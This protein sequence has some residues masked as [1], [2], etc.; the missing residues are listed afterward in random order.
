MI[1]RNNI[2]HYN[3]VYL[4]ALVGL[5]FG[6]FILHPISMALQWIEMDP[7]TFNF[8]S[9][10]TY[11]AESFVHSFKLHMV[12]MS[13]AFGIL[14]LLC[15]IGSGF[16]YR[17]IKVKNK[18]INAKRLLLNKSIPS[19]IKSGENEFVE[20]KS[21]LRY[22]YRQIKTNKNLEE[23]ILK[24]IV[25]FFNAKGGILIIGVDDNGGIL[26]LANDYIT[27]KHKNKDG[28]QQK[29]IQLVSNAFGKSMCSFIHTSFH[30]IDN[31]EI[32]MVLIEP[33][34]QPTYLR[35]ED[36]TLFYLRT[37]NVTNVLTTQE[38]VKYL[39]NRKL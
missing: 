24:S 31:K 26:G 9:L 11:I 23:I 8:H 19:L 7:A 29:I 15:G 39:K 37:G 30:I 25:G 13:I 16:Y 22:D 36:R 12:P 27:L 34:K 3:E 21:S 33:S 20:F 5:L 10:G 4:H 17:S 32:C 35:K 18:T 14:G 2:F 28:F 1:S 38:T 6:Y